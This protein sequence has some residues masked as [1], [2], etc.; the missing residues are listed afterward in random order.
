MALLATVGA[1]YGIQAL[2]AAFAIPF[3]TEKY[4]QTP[5]VV[6]FVDRGALI[7]GFR[8]MGAQILRPVGLGHLPQLYRKKPLFCLHLLLLE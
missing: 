5:R 1:A 8:C 4:T 6:Q 7:V 2:C 3:Q